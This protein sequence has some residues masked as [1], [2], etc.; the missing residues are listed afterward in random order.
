MILTQKSKMLNVGLFYILTLKTRDTTNILLSY[1]T[2][3][4]GI[5]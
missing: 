2:F 4:I 3:T 5:K 1:A